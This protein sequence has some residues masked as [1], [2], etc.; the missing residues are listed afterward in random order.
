MALAVIFAVLLVLGGGDG[1]APPVLAV[2]FAGSRG[3][4]LGRG[5]VEGS[6]GREGEEEVSNW[7]G[8]SGGG[9]GGGGVEDPATP[10]TAVDRS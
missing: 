6:S 9:G 4:L 3:E 2:E 1:G 5:Y 7:D 10:S 8:G